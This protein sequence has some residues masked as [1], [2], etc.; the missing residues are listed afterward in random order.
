M[1]L[2][3]KYTK[4]EVIDTG[5]T[6]IQT[7]KYPVLL[8]K[9][10]PYFDKA[11][12]TE[13]VEQP[14]LENIFTVYENVYVTV[15]SITTFKFN[16][17]EEFLTLANINYRIYES[18]EHRKND[19]EDVIHQDHIVAHHIDYSLN[20]NEMHQAYELVKLSQGCEELIND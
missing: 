4:Y 6:E 8:P 5:R 2:V 14:I 17:P 19:L 10:H 16:T 11:G 3:G 1:A 13:E 12:T 7:V 15:H 18:K 20:Q 9:D